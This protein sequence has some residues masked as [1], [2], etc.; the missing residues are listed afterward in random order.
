MIGSTTFFVSL[1]STN[2][3]IS[4]AYEMI[5]GDQLFAT[6]SSS[7]LIDNHFN[8]QYQNLS[9]FMFGNGE[10]THSDVGYV[11]MLSTYGIIY[12]LLFLV[13]YT[14]IFLYALRKKS[15][16]ENAIIRIGLFILIMLPL[17]SI[18]QFIYGNS[19]GLFVLIA[20]ILFAVFLTRQCSREWSMR[21]QK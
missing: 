17:V 9:N 11:N 4:H 8:Y 2:D 10:K 3:V 19:K 7:R 6:K 15:K 20:M 13:G 5:I 21:E 16:V 12:S 1:Y 18:K 14:L